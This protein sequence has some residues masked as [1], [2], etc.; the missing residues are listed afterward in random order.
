[1]P[2]TYRATPLPVLIVLGEVL[3]KVAVYGFLR[4]VLPIMPEA[5]HHFQELMIILAIVSILYGSIV[6]FSQDE[7]RLVIGYSSIAQVGFIT[8]GI[9]RSTRRAA[10]AR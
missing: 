6:A 9:S 3:S 4:I 7:A 2:D 5:A 1:M 8:L 10:R